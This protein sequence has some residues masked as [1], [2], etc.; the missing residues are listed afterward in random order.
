M[1]KL[2]ANLAGA[3]D[4]LVMCADTG[5]EFGRQSGSN[6]Q[7]QIY[8]SVTFISSWL[9]NIDTIGKTQQE[10]NFSAKRRDGLE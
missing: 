10:K 1:V 9:T 2:A 5:D 4:F 6:T 3:H 8:I 7:E